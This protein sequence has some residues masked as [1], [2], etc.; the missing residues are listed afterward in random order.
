VIYRSALFC[1]STYRPCRLWPQARRLSPNEPLRSGS[2]RHSLGAAVHEKS[3]NLDSLVA[4]Q[5]GRR[6]DSWRLVIGWRNRHPSWRY[7]RWLRILMLGALAE[8][9]GPAAIPTSAESATL[10]PNLIEPPFRE[11][12]WLYRALVGGEWPRLDRA[13]G[14]RAAGRG[15]RSSLRRRFR[16]GP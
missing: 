16:A 9:V 15:P 5:L 7:S 11:P 10:R 4:C 3:G 14:S 1:L 6:C 2:S 13:I 12:R 8:L